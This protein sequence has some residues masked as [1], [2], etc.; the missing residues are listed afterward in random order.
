M[1]SRR[2]DARSLVGAIV[3]L[4]MCAH[5]HAQ[6]FEKVA[7]TNDGFPFVAGNID[8]FDASPAIDGEN[9]YFLARIGSFQGVLFNSGGSLFSIANEVTTATLHEESFS[10]FSHVSAGDGRVGFNASVSNDP[11]IYGDTGAS[12]IM[13]ASTSQTTLGGTVIFSELGNVYMDSGNAAFWATLQEVPFGPEALFLASENAG[14]GDIAVKTGDGMPAASDFFQT[15]GRAPVSQ[16]FLTIFNGRGT[17]TEG[18][19]LTGTLAAERIIDNST[20]STTRTSANYENFRDQISASETDVAFIA[21]LNEHDVRASIVTMNTI[22]RTTRDVTQIAST[23]DSPSAAFGTF[24]DFLDTSISMEATIFTATGSTLVRGESQQG[25]FVFIDDTLITLV[26]R[27]STIDGKLVDEVAIGN[28]SIEDLLVAFRVVFADGSGG[29]YSI[30][31]NTIPAPGVG[32]AM[33]LAG[34]GGVRRTR[35]IG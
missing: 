30:D 7:D 29:I 4:G 5:S 1:Y 20:F 19:Y 15:F 16:G 32:A 9:I 18:I 3:A 34:L 10:G 21:D 25:L 31:L 14:V 8:G 26:D 22:D 35:R 27:L 33:M 13:L 12:Q 28:D 17:T 6:V 2:A 24:T 23:L 11:V